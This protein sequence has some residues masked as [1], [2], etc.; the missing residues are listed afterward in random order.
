MIDKIS[1]LDIIYIGQKTEVTEWVIKLI[2][3]I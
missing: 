3:Q 2:H 1:I